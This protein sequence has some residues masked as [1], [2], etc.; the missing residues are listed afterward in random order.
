MRE[1]L[2]DWMALAKRRTTVGDDDV[3]RRTDAHRD[4]G[5]HIGIW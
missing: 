4:H 3:E 5:I 1:R 2:F